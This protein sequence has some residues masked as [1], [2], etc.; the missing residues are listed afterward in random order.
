MTTNKLKV[1]G[2]LMTLG[3]AALVGVGIWQLNEGT[4]ATSSLTHEGIYGGMSLLGIFLFS[5]GILFLAAAGNDKKEEIKPDKTP[6]AT[7]PPSPSQT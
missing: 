1:T 7:A 3:G 2:G 5:A 4:G 6:E